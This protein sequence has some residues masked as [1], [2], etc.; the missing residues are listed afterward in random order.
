MGQRKKT[1]TKPVTQAFKEKYAL[2]ELIHLLSKRWLTEILLSIEV[3]NIRFSSLKKQL[4]FISDNILAERLLLLEKHQLISKKQV[5]EKPQ[6]M[7]YSLTPAGKQLSELLDELSTF[8]EEEM[9]YSFG[10]T[11]PNS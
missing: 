10:S 3:G 7:E 1:L 2:N 4:S 5:K 11:E 6:N 9:G 8:S